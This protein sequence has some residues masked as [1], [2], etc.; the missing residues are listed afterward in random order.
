M[1]Q[2][3]LWPKNLAGHV[4]CG[5]ELEAAEAVTPATSGWSAEMSEALLGSCAKTAVRP[6]VFPAMSAIESSEQRTVS[7]RLSQSH[8]CSGWRFPCCM[9]H[10]C[11]T[12]HTYRRVLFCTVQ[13]CLQIAAATSCPAA[14]ARLLLT[15]PKLCAV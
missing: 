6:L 2:M 5:K 10:A 1:K 15:P 14:C 9:V 7:R 13:C 11:L 12:A 3:W 4:D 8:C